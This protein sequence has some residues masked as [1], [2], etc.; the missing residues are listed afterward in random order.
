MS[1]ILTQQP[2]ALIKPDLQ[3]LKSVWQRGSEGADS[4]SAGKIARDFE[5][6][7][8]LKV[9]QEMGKTIPESGLLEDG[10]T[11]Q[12]M[13]MFWY[14]LSGDLA[15]KGGFGLW[16]QLQQNLVNTTDVHNTEL[17]R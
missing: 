5:S 17:S 16:K 1:D 3:M 12:I 13:D 2:S 7:L 6:I 14:H 9:L 15:N 11:R 10:M 8:L 4:S